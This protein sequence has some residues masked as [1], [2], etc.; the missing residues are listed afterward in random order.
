MRE[1]RRHDSFDRRAF[2]SSS[3]HRLL[4]WFEPATF[5]PISERTGC[6]PTSHSRALFNETGTAAKFSQRAPNQYQQDYTYHPEYEFYPLFRHPVFSPVF[7]LPCE[8]PQILF[9][10]GRSLRKYHRVIHN[11]MLHCGWLGRCSILH[12]PRAAP[13]MSKPSLGRRHVLI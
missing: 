6:L 3:P 11:R 4:S 12:R 9:R 10:V 2:E 7:P 13:P 8:P 1:N 5:E